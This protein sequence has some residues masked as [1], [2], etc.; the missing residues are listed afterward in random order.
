MNTQVKIILI[1][2]ILLGIGAF[3]YFGKN[4]QS[5]NSQIDL[6]NTDSPKET[7][8]QNKGLNTNTAKASIPLEKVLD[9]GP[10]KDGI[11][12]LINP[13]FISIKEAE[14]NIEDD[15]DGLVVSIG[16]SVKFYPYNIMVWHEIVNDV[17][18]GKPL[19]ITFCPLCGSAI[20]FETTD[21]FGVSG[22]LYESNLLMYDKKTESLWSQSIGTAVVGDR[23]GEKLTVYPSQVLSFKTFKG[24]WPSG[25]VMSTDTGFNRNYELYPYRDYNNNDDVYFPISIKD[26]RFPAKEIM[27]VVNAYNHS[28]A[29]PVKQLGESPVSVDVG[30]NKVTGAIIEGEI[31]VKE[32]SG[33]ILP[34]YHEMWFSWVI[35][36]QEDGVVWKK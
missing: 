2:L 4:N 13:K 33:K 17:V 21:Q 18:G 6:L 5:V 8:F 19:A 10:G 32:A 36:H 31:V 15:M 9:G 3:W 28:V 25:L 11:P 1:V 12:A 24:K 16:N 20:V 29:F 22:K 35:H 30:G 27:Y 26:S 7:A 34:G 23:T 14:K